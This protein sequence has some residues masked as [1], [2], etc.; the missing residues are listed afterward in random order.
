[1]D[2]TK[3]FSM[4][5]FEMT[6]TKSGVYTWSEDVLMSTLGYETREPF[7]KA[8][9][10]AMQACLTMNIEPHNDF[11]KDDD[12][13]RFTRFACYLIVMSC[14]TKKPRV[15]QVQLQ[16]A[17]LANTIPDPRV[18]AAR[19]DRTIIREKVADG[20][21][22]LS[23]TA[24]SHGVVDYAR[25]M[26]AG[27]RGMYNSSLAELEH[28]KGIRPGEHLLDRMDQTELAANLFRITQTDKKIEKENVHG[29]AALENTASEV[30]S[31]VRNAM[32][33]LGGTAP[34]SLPIT[35]HIDEA[36]KKL[37]SARKKMKKL[38]ATKERDELLFKVVE[39]RDLIDEESAEEDPGY[40]PDPE[41]D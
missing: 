18:Q 10:K 29:Q 31:V 39:E 28:I 4:Y 35:E 41:E 3:R 5:A 20:M 7:R 23:A 19:V 24:Q 27:Y 33:Q 11:I 36:K 9:R 14:D 37:K 16:F 22:S 26:D 1:M 38:N 40:T 25:F 2:I 12:G 17:A 15:A 8:V 21:K 30:G 13:Y 6:A 34:E 32:L